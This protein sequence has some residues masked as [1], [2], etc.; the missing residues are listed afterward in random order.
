M[1][2]KVRMVMMMAMLEVT[3]ISRRMTVAK[4]G[5]LLL[6]RIALSANMISTG[7]IVKP[8]RST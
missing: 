6:I 3:Y 7:M 8:L 5:F 4:N 1:S 2:D